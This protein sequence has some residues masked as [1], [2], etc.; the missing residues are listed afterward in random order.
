MRVQCRNYIG[1]CKWK[2]GKIVKR[3]GRLHYLIKLDTGTTWKRHINQIRKIGQD[4]PEINSDDDMDY[5][6]S[7]NDTN[8]FGNAEGTADLTQLQEQEQQPQL[9]N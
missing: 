2:L 3:I 1:K 7:E 4:T 5:N 9:T 6:F 8:D